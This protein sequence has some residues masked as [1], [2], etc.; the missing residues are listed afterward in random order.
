MWKVIEEGFLKLK[1]MSFDIFKMRELR[2][3]EILNPC[4]E[5]PGINEIKEYLRLEIIK[6]FAGDADEFILYTIA[7]IQNRTMNENHEKLA[8]LVRFIKFGIVSFEEKLPPGHIF[9]T[10]FP[11]EFEGKDEVF[12][13]F[14]DSYAADAIMY[15][16][17]DY[18]TDSCGVKRIPFYN[19]FTKDDAMNFSE[20]IFQ[21]LDV[22][23][24]QEKIRRVIIRFESS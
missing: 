5:T 20:N 16:L 7:S 11:D 12:N 22:K 2:N 19:V 10:I 6:S 13:D 4:S 17:I 3:N 24:I 14:Y 1:H 21:V 9:Q 8:Q 23:E 15:F 18:T